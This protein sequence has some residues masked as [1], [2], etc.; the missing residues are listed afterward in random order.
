[1]SEAAANVVYLIV[2]F[3][4][5]CTTVAKIWAWQR[6]RSSALAFIAIC[7]VFGTGAF[8]LATPVVYRSIA[9]ITESQNLAE[10]L[11]FFC[12]LGIFSHTHAMTLIWNPLPEQRTQRQ[13]LAVPAALY[14]AAVATMVIGFFLADIDDVPHPLDF[15]IAYGQ[16]AGALVMLAGFQGGLAYASLATAW[17]FHRSSQ[18]LTGDPRLSRALRHISIATWLVFGYVACVVPATVAGAMGTSVLDPL[19]SLGPVSGTVAA[20]VINW[21]FFGAAVDAWRADRRDFVALVPLWQ[22][23]LSADPRIALTDPNP[24]VE[25]LG[26]L[27]IREWHLFSRMADILSAI[28]GLY[29]YM[30]NEPAQQVRAVA[31]ENRWRPE[32]EQAATAAA[33]LL[34]AV[35]LKLSGGQGR[36][37]AP[38]LPGR[39]LSPAAS[40]AHLVRTAKFLRHPDVRRAATA[41]SAVGTGHARPAADRGLSA[42]AALGE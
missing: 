7:T 5:T 26:L 34:A 13:A 29:P 28:R 37:D 38:A 41:S 12:I 9:E 21:G 15:N 22:L 33:M 17:R 35:E 11:V 27:H 19:H 6:E 36:D 31:K 4:G 32:D 39:D 20:F 23:T 18:F 8:F 30:S 1:M 10:L 24:V 16:D 3:L 42:P 40:R 2:A 25:R 14:A